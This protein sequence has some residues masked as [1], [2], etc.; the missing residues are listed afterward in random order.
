MEL[1]L[2]HHYVN[3][4]LRMPLDSWPDPVNRA[5]AHMNPDVYIPLQG[6]SELGASGL[7]E[8]WDRSAD[9]SRIDVPTLVIGAGF[10]TMDPAHMQWMANEFPQGE[11]LFCPDGSHLA[12]YDDQRT[13]FSGLIRFLQSVDA[14]DS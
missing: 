2:N 1:L 5:M 9:L 6:P 3:H 11:Y 8:Q 4:F 12:L 10:D 14:R 13:F 7:L